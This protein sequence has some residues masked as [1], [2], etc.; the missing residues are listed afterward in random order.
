MKMLRINRIEFAV[1]L[2]IVVAFALLL[3]PAARM[4]LAQD[5]KSACQNNL[6]QWGI[7]CKMYANENKGSLYPPPMRYHVLGRRLPRGFAAE[8]LYPEYWTDISIAICPADPRIDSPLADQKT[9]VQ[10]DFIGQ[11]QAITARGTDES[12]KKVCLNTLLSQPISYVYSGYATT[13]MPEFTDATL[14][15]AEALKAEWD[16]NPDSYQSWTAAEM[17]AA[18]CPNWRSIRRGAAYELEGVIYAKNDIKQLK[19]GTFSNQLRPENKEAEERGWTLPEYLMLSEGVER[20]MITD[21]NNPAASAMAQSSIGLMWD[22][23]GP[24][25]DIPLNAPADTEVKNMRFHHTPGACNVLFM[26]GHVEFV[27]FSEK[28]PCTAALDDG[29]VS[30]LILAVM[31]RAGG[32]G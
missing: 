3:T 12:S 11:T 17:I 26:D 13:S 19:P 28:Y 18:G 23:W 27:K 25:M 9:G 4:A 31:E 30:P 15:H 24:Q 10:Q 20:F 5:T 7:V 16:A 6:K 1:L 14:S 8:A 2:T 32:Q 29:T 21:I 22:A